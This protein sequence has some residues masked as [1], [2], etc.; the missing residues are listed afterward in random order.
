MVRRAQRGRDV[1]GGVDVSERLD[2]GRQFIG[3]KRGARRAASPAFAYRASWRT[4]C[5]ATSRRRFTEP[6]GGRGEAPSGAARTPSPRW[7]RET[8]APDVFAVSRR[9]R[10][11]TTLGRRTRAS[12]PGR[13][14]TRR[15]TRR[16]FGRAPRRA[17]GGR[18]AP[19][20]RSARA[21]PSRLCRAPSCH[22]ARSSRTTPKSWRTTP[23]RGGASPR[24]IPT[25]R[26]ATTSAARLVATPSP[27]RAHVSRAPRSVRTAITPYQR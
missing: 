25:A 26:L 19:A 14:E 27:V 20:G 11:W 21:P 15:E 24:R 10:R 23:P 7:R 16:R 9:F 4:T 5:A 6:P 12:R 2:G 3:P 13:R 18:S 8:R 1:P 22:R 17:R